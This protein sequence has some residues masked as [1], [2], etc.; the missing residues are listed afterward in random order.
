MTVG[1]MQGTRKTALIVGASRG[2]GLGLARELAARGWQVTGTAR[3]QA[4]QLDAAANDAGGRLA[5]EHVDINDGAGVAAFVARLAGERFA[6]VLVNAGVYG[7]QHQSVDEATPED[8]GALVFTNAVAPVR[9]ARLLLPLVADGGAIAFMSS[10]MGSVADN[11]SGGMDLYRASKAALNSLT[12]GFAV[13]DVGARP[14]TVLN[15]HPG[16]VRT[17]MG[18][19]GAPLSVEESVRGL[20]DVVEDQRGPGHLFLDYQNAVVPW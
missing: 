10:R 19:D 8:M 3:D 17:A 7:P 5:I 2:L 11:L 14:V 1:Q 4:P 13:N 6:F 16:W 12:R 9:L 18:G 20:A 15:L